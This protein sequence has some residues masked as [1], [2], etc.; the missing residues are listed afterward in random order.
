MS[1]DN[2]SLLDPLVVSLQKV[3]PKNINPTVDPISIELRT[4]FACN[5][6]IMCTNIVIVFILRVLKFLII[7]CPLLMIENCE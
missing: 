2:N 5:L 1:Y 7:K 3:G 6:Q 4:A